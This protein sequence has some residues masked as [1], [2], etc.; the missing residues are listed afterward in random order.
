MFWNLI[1]TTRGHIQHKFWTGFSKQPPGRRTTQKWHAKFKEEGCLCSRKK[2]A[3]SP[4]TETIERVRNIFQRSPRKSIRRTSLELQMPSTTVW[5]VVREYLHMIPYKLHLLQHLKDTDKSTGE[6]FYTQ[7]LVMLEEDAFDNRLVLSDEA[8][9]HV[10]GKVNK[11]NT[12]K[13]G[14]KHPHAIQEHARDSPK[15]NVFCTISKKCVYGPFFFEGTTVNSEAYLAMLQNCLVELLFEGE[16]ADF[17]FQK[18]GA[19]PH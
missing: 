15:V 10:I 13:W 4:S 6:D 14:T 3:P 12:R 17:I 11:H 5:R 7:M 19:P 18:D 2:T 8:T 9:F 1:K 16:R